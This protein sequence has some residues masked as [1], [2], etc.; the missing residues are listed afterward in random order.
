MRITLLL[1]FFLITLFSC[2][3]K[4]KE[5]RASKKSEH[6]AQRADSVLSLMTIDEKIGQLNLPGAGDINT[7]QASNSNIA[8]SIRKG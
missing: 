6:Y 4:S 3:Q 8:G 2:D 7:G 5:D 1:A